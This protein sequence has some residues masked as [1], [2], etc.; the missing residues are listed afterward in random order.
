[1]TTNRQR[2]VE[3]E[4]GRILAIIDAHRA[5]LERAGLYH[6]LRNLVQIG[7]DLRDEEAVGPNDAPE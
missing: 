4:R 5:D 2:A 7:R 6:R 3:E 1:M